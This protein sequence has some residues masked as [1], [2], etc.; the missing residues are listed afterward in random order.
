MKGI[1][2]SRVTDF[3]CSWGFDVDRRPE[4]KS[5][6]AS[7]NLYFWHASSSTVVARPHLP[8]SQLEAQTLS[9]LSS[10]PSPPT[11]T[12]SGS[13]FVDFVVASPCLPLSQREAQTLSSLSSKPSPPTITA[14][15]S[16]FVDFVVA[17]PRLPLSQLEAQTLSSCRSQLKAARCIEI[18]LEGLTS[19][20]I[21]YWHKISWIHLLHRS[22]QHARNKILQTATETQKENRI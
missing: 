13:G 5:F 14:S 2:A 16:G 12:A 15:G 21:I 10:K 4:M 11:I 20:M 9:S 7:L 6:G 19:K 22:H 17:G 8:L 1:R 18:N 3:E